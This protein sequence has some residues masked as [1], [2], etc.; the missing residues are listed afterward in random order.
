MV[1]VYMPANAPGHNMF[2]HGLPP[3]TD[4]FCVPLKPIDVKVLE[5]MVTKVTHRLTQD[6]TT[7]RVDW[8]REQIEKFTREDLALCGICKS[9]R[10]LILK[11][12]SHCHDAASLRKKKDKVYKKANKDMLAHMSCT[13]AEMH[14]HYRPAGGGRSLMPIGRFLCPNEEEKVAEFEVPQEGLNF[15]I[16]GNSGIIILNVCNDRSSRAP[17]HF[18][19]IA[20]AYVTKK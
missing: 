10:D 2:P 12:A 19:N 13:T 20:A 9:F 1:D 17:L 8:W 18:W 6:K 14:S 16:V 7:H 5:K 3:N 15:P 4:V 11:N